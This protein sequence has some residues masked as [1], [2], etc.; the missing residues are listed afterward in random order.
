VAAYGAAIWLLRIEGRHE[1]AAVLAKVPVLGLF[2]R[3][4]L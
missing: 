3:R 2:F 1:L 4:A